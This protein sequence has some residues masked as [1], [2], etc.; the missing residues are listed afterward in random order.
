MIAFWERNASHG[1]LLCPMFGSIASFSVVDIN[2]LITSGN[3]LLYN[4]ADYS[5][6]RCGKEKHVAK[7]AGH[8]T[9]PP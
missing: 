5:P 9:G 6:W 4:G 7:P 2:I 1:V 3:L 8:A